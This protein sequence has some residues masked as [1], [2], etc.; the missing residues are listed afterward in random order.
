MKKEPRFYWLLHADRDDLQSVESYEFEGFDVRKLWSGERFDDEFP[1]TVRICLGEGAL[2]DFPGNPLSLLLMSKRLIAIL[3][4]FFDN[5]VQLIPIT[6]YS[7]LGN[8][9]N[10]YLVANP[11]GCV[12]AI[13]GKKKATQTTSEIKLDR[14]KVPSDRHFFRLKHQPLK[15][16]FSEQVFN[17]I[18][19]KG[20]AGL[21]CVEVPC[22]AHP[23]H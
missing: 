23:S 2:S 5:Y 16:I 6:L 20:L 7:A 9:I 10:D 15:I 19:K 4:P 1:A 8:P 3:Q 12:D 11:I 14:D 18:H 21:A 22:A 17:A 13:A